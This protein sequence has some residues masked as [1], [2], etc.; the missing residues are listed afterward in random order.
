MPLVKIDI[1]KG[2]RTPEE[3]KKLAASVQEVMVE[4]FAAPKLDRYQVSDL[5]Y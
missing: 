2:A 3:I 1:V 5:L 4:H